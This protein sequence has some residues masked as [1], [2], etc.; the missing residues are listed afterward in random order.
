MIPNTKVLNRFESAVQLSHEIAVYIPSTIGGDIPRDNS[1]Y[2]D[3]TSSAFSNMFGGCTIT[4]G[5]GCWISDSKG[6]IKESIVIVTASCV[7]LANIE[8][9]YDIALK[10][11]TELHQ[12]AIT[13]K[14]DGT[15]YLI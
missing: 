2:V 4:K 10:I 1:Q 8:S 14:I 6:L 3:S 13:V 15:L 9:V 12:E 7:N 5:Q 11:K